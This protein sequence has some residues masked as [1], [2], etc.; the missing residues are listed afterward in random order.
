MAVIT[1]KETR[2]PAS[3][4]Q[5]LDFALLRAPLL[6]IES[7]LALGNA[8]ESES[9]AGT[10]LVLVDP[11]VRQAL[12]IGSPSLLDTL[13]RLAPDDDK[14]PRVRA[15]LRRFL[16]R[17]S[18]RPT[19]YGTFAG[20]TMAEW[21]DRTNVSLDG[22]TR[23]RTRVDMDWLVQY[24]LALEGQPLIRNQ[25]QWVANS[26]AWIAYGRVIVPEGAP[27]PQGTSL[28]SLSVAATPAVRKALELARDPILYQ[29]LVEK[30]VASVP[31]A[32]VE[33]VEGLLQQLW[34]HGILRTQLMPPVT[35]EDPMQWVRERLTEIRSTK[36]LLVQLE[37][38]VRA[39]QACDMQAVQAS[40]A[41]R[42]AAVHAATL[43]R[44][45]T[46]M[47]LQV[48]MALGTQGRCLSSA[49]GEEA[50]RMAHL[51]FRLTP[52]PD[53]PGSIW[54]FRQAFIGKY[55]LDREVPLLELLHPE[56]GIGPLGQHGW[57]A[58][59]MDAARSA[60]RAETLQRL[61]LDAIRD[62]ERV[63]ELDDHTF[64][65]LETQK[66]A[67]DQMPSSIDLNL[68]VLAASRESIDAGDFQLMLGPNVGAPMAG[69]NLGRFTGVLGVEA[70]GALERSARRDERYALGRITAEL[71]YLP[72]NF[73]TANVAVRPAV[74]HYE[75]V[76]RV[77]AGVDPEHVIPMHEL[78][79]GI[80]DGRF[81]V[82]WLA[83]DV[84]VWFASGHMLNSNQASPECYLLS[85]IS[86]DGIAQ[87]T[88]FDWGPAGGYPFLPRV[89]SGR[90]ILHCAQWR[91]DAEARGQTELGRPEM[92]A[93]WFAHWR[94]RWRMP[95]LVYLTWADNRLLYDLDDPAQLDDLRHEVIKAKDQGQCL[96]Q[97]ALPG[98]EHA[99]LPSVSGGHHIVEL[100]VSLGL[101]KAPVAA[102]IVPA[103]RTRS[104]EPA[105]TPEM[106]LRPLGSD[107]IFLKLYGPRSGSDELLAGPVRNFCHEVEEASLADEWFFVRYADPE[108]HIRLRFRGSPKSLM[109]SLLPRVCTWAE[110]LVTQGRCFKFAFDTY[111]REVERYGGPDGTAAAETLFAA[112]SRL[113]VD[114]IAAVP[115]VERVFLAVVL[116]DYLLDALRLD[117]AARLA[118]LKQTVMSRKEVSDE[119]RTRRKDLI[120]ALC[121]PSQLNAAIRDVCDQHRGRFAEVARRLALLESSQ[122]LTQPM[123]K[124][125]SSYVHMHCN[126]LMNDPSAE[127]RVLGLLLRARDAVA[128]Q[129][130]QE[131]EDFVASAMAAQS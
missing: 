119:Y 14:A 101:T 8:Q 18:T 1:K 31:R 128:H 48:D 46:E 102:P 67:P 32:T 17:M 54:G 74:R 103:A 50:A 125:Y 120:A 127:R 77:S 108:A 84:E 131:P 19:P 9:A 83:R 15:K 22:T 41:L 122:A 42:K 110:D 92:F 73:R 51:L 107:W 57:G 25:L 123:T 121:Y 87:L 63:I 64:A 47:P 33:K 89:Q 111:E 124:L 97:E 109:E 24:V 45:Q 26:A 75:V 10:K 62:G 40:A 70:R 37:G 44:T 113:I 29:A 69:R 79:V 38:L 85:E 11:R 56:R 117:E 7:Y 114:L 115:R 76:Y 30:L 93:D 98:P 20:V 116:V 21:G 43:G 99:W 60:R 58:G 106:R 16:V 28:G 112:D 104:S 100:V 71:A 34:Q 66:N 2:A 88:G 129:P 94:E 82:R 81:Y 78:V 68:F 27:I 23:T 36:A 53:G 5:P 49:L 61:A 80:R 105:L 39:I 13:D 55:G 91:L 90:C 72:K 3:V 96:L 126:R 130:K 4:Y 52:S 35:F 6:P 86:R 65:Q 59:A 12:A 95:R 118:W